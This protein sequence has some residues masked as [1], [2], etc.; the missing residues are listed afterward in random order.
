[1][2]PTRRFLPLLRL[3]PPRL[4]RAVVLLLLGLMVAGRVLSPVGGSLEL[5]ASEGPVFL[6]AELCVSVPAVEGGS[7]GETT[8]SLGHDCCWWMCGVSALAL[9]VLAVVL[10]LLLPDDRRRWRGGWTVRTV[11]PPGLLWRAVCPSR[12]PPRMAFS[13]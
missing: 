6:T 9:A 2:H 12:A 10:P 7:S 3:L 13:A 11:A 5:A 4:R 8:P 1:M